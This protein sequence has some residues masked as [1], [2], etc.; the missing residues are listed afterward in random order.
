MSRPSEAS[1]KSYKRSE[2]ILAFDL[3]FAFSQSHNGMIQ[4]IAHESSESEIQ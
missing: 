2:F 3:A 1:K 4:K